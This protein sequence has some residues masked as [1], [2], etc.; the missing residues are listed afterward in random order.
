VGVRVQ[1]PERI[2]RGSRAEK[3][4]NGEGAHRRAECEKRRKKFNHLPRKETFVG[5]VANLI[6]WPGK[7]VLE[8]GELKTKEDPTP[9]EGVAPPKQMP[10]RPNDFRTQYLCA[11][12]CFNALPV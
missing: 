9:G 2:E 4:D 11:D 10:L 12:I 1:A 7:N 8:Y 5:E 3:Q 6:G